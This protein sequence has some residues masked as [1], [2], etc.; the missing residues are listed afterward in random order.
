VN[1]VLLAI[2]LLTAVIVGVVA[3]WI[4]WEWWIRK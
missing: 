1:T 2:A 4:M 3:V